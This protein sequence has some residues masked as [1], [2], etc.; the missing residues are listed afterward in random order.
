MPGIFQTNVFNQGED[1]RYI[2]KFWNEAVVTAGNAFSTFNTDSGQYHNFEMF[3][4]P[5]ADGDSSELTI[6]LT[7]GDYVMGLLG[8]QSGIGGIQEIYFDAD[9][10]PV[11]IF[12]RYDPVFANNV[13][14]SA[15]VTIVNP[16]TVVRSFTNGQNPASTDFYVSTTRIWFTAV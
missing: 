9:V 11:A 10:V 6:E 5:P 13:M 8:V 2:S 4:E 16:T 1:V 3:N 7:P 15:N 14:F 12:D